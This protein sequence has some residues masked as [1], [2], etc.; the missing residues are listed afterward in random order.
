MGYISE[1][2]GSVG[3]TA[4]PFAEAKQSE[5]ALSNGDWGKSGEEV[6]ELAFE[7]C[8]LSEGLLDFSFGMGRPGA[9]RPRL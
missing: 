3:S 4:V 6:Y 2:A 8:A 1:A 5:E 7:E 9:A